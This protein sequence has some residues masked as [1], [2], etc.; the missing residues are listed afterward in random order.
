MNE[1]ADARPGDRNLRRQRSRA[2]RQDI[3][4]A[5]IDCFV[6][7]GYL[8]TTTTN[9]A[10][11]AGVTRGAVQHY[12]P[13]TRHALEASIDY[14]RE[15]WL[16]R[17]FDAAQNTPPGKDYIDHAVDNLWRFVNDRLYIA[18]QEL[19]ASARTDKE[20]YRI[21]YPAARAYDNARRDMGEQTWPDL[22]KEDKQTFHRNRDM[23]RFLLEGITHSILTYDSDTRVEQQ[24]QW[25]RDY[26]HQ[27]WGVS[28]GE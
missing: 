19:V 17:Y 4:E 2:T 9:I 22:I 16:E 21:I 27:A 20:L 11:R 8:R 7:I 1:K 15:K 13:T 10:K 3:V 18:W 23:L 28:R 26:M 12:F 14:L 25:L 5:T 24:L 6:E